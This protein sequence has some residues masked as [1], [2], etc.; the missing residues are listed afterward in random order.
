VS[1]RVALLFLA[2]A[3]TAACSRDPDSQWMKAGPYTTAEFDQDVAACS[4]GSAL[5]AAC[6]EARG[7]IAVGGD[8]PA[9]TAAEKE[10]ERRRELY[11]TPRP[12]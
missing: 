8:V 10:Q 5:D 2:V 7:W 4:R 1:V 12:Q 11:R 9:Q 6:M 3:A